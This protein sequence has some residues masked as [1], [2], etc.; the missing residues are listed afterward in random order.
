MSLAHLLLRR[1]LQLPERTAVFHGTQPHAS[2]AMWAARSAGV[3]QRMREAGLQP[4]SAA[5]TAERQAHIADLADAGVFGTKGTS[6]FARSAD[7]R[8]EA[9]RLLAAARNKD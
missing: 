3:A 5:G 7:W 8:T 1:A 6:G 4:H 9:D 2:H